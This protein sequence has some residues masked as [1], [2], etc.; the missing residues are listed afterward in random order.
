MC[1]AAAAKV[2]SDDQANCGAGYIFDGVI[3]GT[4]VGDMV[5]AIALA[6]EIGAYAAGICKTLHPVIFG[7]KALDQINFDWTNCFEAFFK[8]ADFLQGFQSV[9]HKT[10]RHHK[11]FLFTLS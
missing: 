2:E 4:H 9:D 1:S 3:F 11:Q 5:G 8:V 10:R 7:I 6:T